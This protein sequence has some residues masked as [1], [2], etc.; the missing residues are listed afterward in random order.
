MLPESSSILNN[1][2]W[3]C[4]HNGRDWTVAKIFWGA[5]LLSETAGSR[6]GYVIGDIH[7]CSRA[8]D[9]L[10][11]QM[12][13]SP[14][15]IVVILGDAVDRGPDSR[16]VLQRLLDIGQT[17]ELVYILG[18]HEEMMLDALSGHKMDRWL[19]HGGD[20]TLDSYGADPRN[21]PSSHFDLL[22]STVEYWEGPNEICVHAN[23]EPGVELNEQ[24]SV[25]LRWQKLSGR[26]FH[27][28]SGK[29]VI[30]GHSGVG[31]G[32]PVVQNGWVCLDTMAY[33]GGVL[34]AMNLQTGE[35]MQARQN[36]E[37]RRG[38]FVHELE[39]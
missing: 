29:R 15:D 19:R 25:W 22:D 37:F 32:A 7:G 13:L 3:I 18:N 31:Y 23:L 30:C 17:C 34:S 28:S 20:A 21:I 33:A 5:W 11:G 4:Q 12:N 14:S 16:R 24:R 2:L 27:H 38:V 10:V 26:E 35:I 1:Q 36:G 39:M 6:H 9:V 8:L